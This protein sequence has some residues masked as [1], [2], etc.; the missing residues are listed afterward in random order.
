VAQPDSIAKEHCEEIGDPIRDEDP[1]L[2]LD[3]L[4]LG[5]PCE[6]SLVLDAEA[7]KGMITRPV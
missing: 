4:T 1:A 3:Y 2:L 6:R 5:F 7:A